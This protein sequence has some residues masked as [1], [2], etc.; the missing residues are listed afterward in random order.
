MSSSARPTLKDV[1]RQARVSARTVSRVLNREPRTSARTRSRVL[2]VIETLGFRP[3]AMARH[4]RAGSRDATVGL[5]IPDLANPFYGSIARGVEA[6]IRTRGLSLVIA[7]S[8]EDP[9]RE[10]E[11]VTKLLER[12][13]MA[14]IVVPATG[15]DH[16][17]LRAERKRGLPIVFVDRPPSGLAADAVL[18]ANFE[19][20]ARAVGHLARHGHRRI[21]FIGDVPSTLYTRRERYRG[22]REALARAGVAIDPDLVEAGHHERDA[23]AAT[24]R[25]LAAPR[26]PTA[27]FAANNFACMGV[28]MALARARRRDIALVGFDDF[29]LADVFEPGTSVIA[30]DPDR[31]GTTAAA[32]VLARLDGDRSGARGTVLPTELRTR[33]SGELRP[34]GT[35]AQRAV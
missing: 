30:Q 15:S 32:R 17:Y 18:S 35:S 20:A 23:A 22:Y 13:V 25:L 16:R 34:R 26:P 21:A 10:R 11:V 6:T 19:G 4:M 7:S 27:I 14:L 2:A 3:N 5:I 29:I 12:Q 31:L 28:L 8:D 33:G 24:E 9:D 1:A